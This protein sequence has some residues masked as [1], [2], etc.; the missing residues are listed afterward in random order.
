MKFNFPHCEAC[1]IEVHCKNE[2]Q[3]HIFGTLY[4]HPIDYARPFTT[5]LGEFLETFTTRK[6]KLTLLGDINIDLNKSN[7]VSTEYLNTINSAGFSTLINQP[8]RIFH[9][10]NTNS[11]SCSIID[12]IITNNSSCFSKVGILIADISDHLPLFS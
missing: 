6:T 7:P 11:V 8:T 3:N 12:H 9:Y 5:Y 10:E 2:K 4:R 1:F